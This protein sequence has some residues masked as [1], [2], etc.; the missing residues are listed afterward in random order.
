MPMKFVSARVHGTIDY[1]FVALF[2]L[3]PTIFG[4][5]GLPA[6]LATG[7]AVVHLALT[8]CT[9]FPLGLV[10]AVPFS[11]HGW[12]ELIAGTTVV[13]SPWLFAFSE[14]MAARNFFLGSG[15]AMLFVW[16]LSDYVASRPP[17]PTAGRDQ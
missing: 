6:T 7:I 5:S 17:A 15:V 13:L 14:S 11:A 8:M 12:F 4:F 2:L 9:A 10:K 16:L 3:A 1:L